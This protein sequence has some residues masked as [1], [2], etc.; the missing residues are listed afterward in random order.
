MIPQV[1]ARA[2]ALPLFMKCAQSTR[3]E[4]PISDYYPETGLGT[5][6]HVYAGQYVL[7]G[8][9]DL[10]GLAKV[11][12]CD[13][14]ELGFLAH[15]VR[16][17][18]ADVI[19]AYKGL[20][21]RVLAEPEWSMSIDDPP[22]EVTGT[23]DAVVVVSDG[24]EDY[25][26]VI[27]WK[28]GRRDSEYREQLLAYG[29]LGLLFF[30]RASAVRARVV[31][32]REM[33]VELYSLNRSELDEWYDRLSK[34][35]KDTTFRPGQHCSFCPR[36]FKC[37]AR[38]DMT[39]TS[40]SMLSLVR[41]EDPGLTTAVDGRALLADRP[42]G[43]QLDLY[44]RA[45]DV[46]DLAERVLG[47]MRSIVEEKGP[48]S[49]GGVTLQ[50]TVEK[51]RTLTPGVAWPVLQKH[52]SEDALASAVTVHITKAE[53]GAAANKHRGEGAAAKRALIADLEAAGAIKTH[54]VRKLTERRSK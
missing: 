11:Y 21:Y 4:T 48:V 16:T 34:Q 50:I 17:A 51:R 2:S 27:D 13:P 14:Q 37:E 29:V 28:T 20:Q 31:W 15:Q 18:W 1:L 52:L 39:H 35:A 30:G 38:A 43:E 12:G 42:P 49:A 10:D 44:H 7:S 45:Q 25:I 26:E 54:E 32:L 47:E 3:G 53:D 24:G 41:P 40:V 9:V 33:E 22:G 5:A 8:A 36:R 46:R 6:A 19:G 23:P